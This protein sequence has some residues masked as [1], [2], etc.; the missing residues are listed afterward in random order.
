MAD[1]LNLATR[2][3]KRHRHRSSYGRQGVN[4]D[5][6]LSK[7]QGIK[8]R[9]ELRKEIIAKDHLSKNLYAGTTSTKALR[10]C[11]NASRPKTSIPFQQRQSLKSRDGFY[12][13]QR[14]TN[15]LNYYQ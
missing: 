13:N 7:C 9:D 6:D 1:Y 11:T 8:T 3:S 4:I 10:S 12:K 15:I 2:D 5:L 14:S